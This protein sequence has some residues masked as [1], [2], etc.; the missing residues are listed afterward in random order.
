MRAYIIEVN[1]T[2]YSP[3]QCY[4]TMTLGEIAHAFK[5]IAARDGD[6]TPVYFSHDN[7][8]TFGEFSLEEADIKYFDD[9]GEEVSEEEYY[10]DDD[11]DEDEDEDDD[12]EGDEE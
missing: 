5:I 9:D 7:G 12:E 10:S 4:D 6:D 3:D 11:D 2:G 1:R 8:Y